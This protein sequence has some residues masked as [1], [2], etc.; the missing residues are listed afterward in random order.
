MLSLNYQLRTNY[1]D[2]EVIK[3]TMEKYY[4]SLRE[5]QYDI[6]TSIKIL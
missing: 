5:Y 6:D 2:M 3:S 1:I 4:L